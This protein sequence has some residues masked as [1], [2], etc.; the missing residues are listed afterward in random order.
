MKLEIVSKAAG[1]FAVI[2]P[3]IWAGITYTIGLKNEQM[4][5]NFMNF[6]NLVAEIYNGGR[7]S[8]LVHNEL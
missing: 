5:R 6:H 7:K 4:S 3:I 2:A 1:I 8:M